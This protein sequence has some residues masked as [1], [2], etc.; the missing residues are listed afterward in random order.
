MAVHFNMAISSDS[1]NKAKMIKS[2]FNNSKIELSNGEIATVLSSI[3]KIDTDFVVCISAK[4][5]HMGLNDSND[6]L[7]GKDILLEFEN[8]LIR[9]I[10][11]EKDIDFNF[12]QF[13]CEIYDDF[14]NSLFLQELLEDYKGDKKL[15]E[16][17][18]SGLIVSNKM[19]EKHGLIDRFEKFN[20]NYQW[21]NNKNKSH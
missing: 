15:F 17:R 3:E 5:M 14:I 11:N 18:Y 20:E 8:N 10:K 7:I 21:I 19:A 16:K 9:K 12:A 4:G 2:I 6:K 1:E 13:Q